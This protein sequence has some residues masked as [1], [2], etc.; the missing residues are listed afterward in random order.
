DDKT[1]ATSAKQKLLFKR[2]GVT[3][4]EDKKEQED[5]TLPASKIPEESEKVND[6]ISASPGSSIQTELIDGVIEEVPTDSSRRSTPA[7]DGIDEKKPTIVKQPPLNRKSTENTGSEK[8]RKDTV[9]KPR[10][11]SQ[12]LAMRNRFLQNDKGLA[13]GM[14][15]F[16]N[17]KAPP[18]KPLPKPLNK[19]NGV[20]PSEMKTSLPISEENDVGKEKN[21]VAEV[22]S[23]AAPETPPKR[24][25][26][27][28]IVKKSR[29]SNLP[30]AKPES[31]NS[32]MEEK[33]TNDPKTTSRL[34]K[35]A[36]VV[37]PKK[38]IS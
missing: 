36:P 23:E 5:K 29:E 16:T 1:P 15:D 19:T 20:L 34:P 4:L 13:S 35:V 21:A 31:V 14:L 22:N 32:L 8:E 3:E 6:T 17:K 7:V 30:Q 2:R 12:V 26:I 25:P 38:R 18:P 33:K 10:R 11:E 37:P 28:K 9:I 27:K 24:I